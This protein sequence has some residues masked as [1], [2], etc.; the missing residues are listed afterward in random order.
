[1]QSLQFFRGFSG[2]VMSYVYVGLLWL[3]RTLR[4]IKVT[5]LEAAQ[6]AIER[7]NVLFIVNHPSL[8]ETIA[9]PA[10]FWPYPWQE[11]TRHVPYSVADINLF[12]EKWQQ[13]FRLVV[14]SRDETD[15]AKRVNDLASKRLIRIFKRERGVVIFYPEGG[16]TFKGTE[17]ITDR[18]RI[19]RIPRTELVSLAARIGAEIIPVWAE[20]GDCSKERSLLLSYFMLFTG[21]QMTLH[22]GRPLVGEVT[23]TSI[24][25]ALLRAGRES[26]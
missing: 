23:E 7:G 2:T 8:L 19:V 16:R 6:A 5:N 13:A 9:L 11:K 22:F 15:E 26:G 18:E 4:L 1:M 3:A 12:P 25:Q 14:V 24:A 20:H 10:L 17:F 21:R